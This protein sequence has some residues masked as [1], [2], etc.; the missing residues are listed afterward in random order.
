MKRMT[1]AIQHAWR[2]A[3]IL[4]C[5]AL[6]LQPVAA[7]AAPG[8]SPFITVDQFGYLPDAD[9]V[10][11]LRDPVAGHDAA[12][13]YSPGERLEVVSVT[14][15]K[16]VFEG[17]PVTWNEG[18]VDDMSGDRAW[19]FDF[20]TVQAPGRY[21][22]LDSEN[23]QRSPEFSIGQD[24]YKPVLREAL[25]VFFY[26]RAG[27]P[28]KPPYADPAWQDDASH[29]GPGQDGE[30]RLYS[31]RDDASTELDLS[32]G[33]YDAGDFHRYTAWAANNVITM[34]HAW[35]ENPQAWDD[36]AGI[37]ESGNGIPDLVDEI[38]FG[39]EWQKKMQDGA[40]GAG[41]LSILDVDE[42]SPPSSAKGPSVYGP[43]T[44]NAS[45]V[46]AASFAIAAIAVDKLPGE[47]WDDYSKDLVRRA[48]AAWQWAVEN[49]D[50]QFRNNEG[51]AVGVGYGQQETDDEGRARSKRRAAVYLFAATGKPEYHDYVR[52]AYRETPVIRDA[53]QIETYGER[54]S[55]TMLYYTT[56]PG[57]DAGIAAEIREHYQKAMQ[58]EHTAR[59]VVEGRSA[60]RAYMPPAHFRWGSNREISRQGQLHLNLL[61]YDF[62]APAAYDAREVGLGVLHYIH[63]V[64]PQGMTYLSN[65]YAVGATRAPNE[66]YHLW[67]MDGSPRWDRVGVSEFG[68]APG[69]LVGGPNP[70]YDRAECCPNSCDTPEVN[71]ACD[72]ESI[73]PPKNQPILKSYKDFN[74]SWPINSWEVTENHNEYQVAYLR[75]LS[76]F[77]GTKDK[78]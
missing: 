67:Y 22:V 40:G 72:S 64:N 27:F 18:R 70:N 47:S 14:D 20:S 71:A 34:S 57:A 66:F 61:L 46:G 4:T 51:D 62:D 28:K 74:T 30:A 38:L 6:P 43:A 3:L 53:G 58:G 56:L 29:L 60:Y 16:V 59:A 49:P 5:S 45:L 76:N 26:Q 23:A 55:M 37:P 10:A 32:G 35:L 39:L 13:E 24:V 48:E 1:H 42:A 31:A 78:E 8:L 50:A 25:R 33:W 63:G 54:E 52:K 19:W 41:L 65:M 77:V 2:A 7:D 21:Y 11:V 73:V 69:F 44:A 15:G 68:P 75:L 9:K 17:A 36:A 12:L